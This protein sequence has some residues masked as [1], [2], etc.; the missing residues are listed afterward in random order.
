MIFKF[1]V[2]LLV[3]NLYTP[4]FSSTKEKVIIKMKLINILSFDFIQTINEKKEK[5]SC[6]IKY[7][8]KIYCKYE[9]YNKKIIV[10][11]G[12][13]LVIKNSSLIILLLI[14]YPR[15]AFIL[16]YNACYVST[17]IACMYNMYYN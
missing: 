15:R 9:G 11:D 14:S 13:S 2:I 5:G 3:L 7:P 17:C 16:A 4:T 6:I 10:S 8:K 12:R 1:T